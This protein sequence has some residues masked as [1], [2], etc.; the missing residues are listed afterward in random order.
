MAL[1]HRVRHV[2]MLT[3]NQE[4][5]GHIVSARTKGIRGLIKVGENASQIIPGS[6]EMCPIL[7]PAR[8]DVAL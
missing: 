3:N 4:Q 5:V 7:A 6:S 1:E 8:S 2:I